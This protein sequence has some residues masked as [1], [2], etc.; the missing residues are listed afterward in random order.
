MTDSEALA[1]IVALLTS[2]DGRLRRAEGSLDGLVESVGPL[3]AKAST[4]RLLG[5]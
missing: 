5:L 4:S 3:I 2:I 1:T